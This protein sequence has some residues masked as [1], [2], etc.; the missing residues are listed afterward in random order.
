MHHDAPREP[1]RTHFVHARSQYA[2]AVP[3]LYVHSWPGS[4]IE[5]QRVIGGLVGPASGEGDNADGVGFHV[6]CPSIPGFGF[7]DAS[8]EGEFGVYGAAEVF[9]GLMDRLGYK[10]FVVCGAGW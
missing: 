6:V 4:F 10:K 5:V 7:S 2:N 1:L 8:E 3:L 9:A